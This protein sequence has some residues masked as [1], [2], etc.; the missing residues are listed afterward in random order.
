MLA[1]R[2]LTTLALAA[3]PLT[4]ACDDGLDTDDADI[5]DIK[6]SSVKNQSIGNCWVYATIGWAESLHLTQSGEELN[7]SE[8]WVSY[9]HWFEQIAGPQSGQPTIAQL[10]KGQI[11]TGGWYG[12]AAELMRKYGVISEGKFIPEEAEAARSARQSSALSAINESLKNGALKDPV[13]RR[14][15][16]LVRK[17][18]DKAWGLTATTTAMMDQ[19]FGAKVDKTLLSSSIV[20]PADSGIMN[21]KDISVG[22]KISLADAIGTPASSF[23]VLQ[24]K[25]TYAWNEV[26]Y[27]TTTK[28][29]RD[30]FK[31]MQSSMHAGMPVIMVW[32]VD[33]AGL[34]SQ[35]EFLAPPTTPG[36]QGGHMTIV[37]DYQVSNVPG[38]GTLEAGTLITD[39]KAL[40]AALADEAT[41]DFIRMKNSWGSSLA[42]PEASPD[43]RGYYDIYKA[44]IDG[45]ITKCKEANG[46][47][48]GQKS[49]GPGL[50]SLVLPPESFVTASLVKEGACTDICV[51][52]PA[53]SSSCDEC[54]DLICSE[55]AFCCAN[56]W[57]DLCVQKA[58]DICELGCGQ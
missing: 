47:K 54:T 56:A 33:F 7:L 57:D 21:P 3:L 5:T 6:N 12:V 50:T 40:T 29:R 25:G 15:R 14:D 42:P 53:R 19:T 24:R 44:Y 38:F 36:R 39:N 35:N 55:D 28:A 45:P 17:E 27:P 20:I 30:F 10:D 11:G 32:Y 34:N 23:N 49:T 43:L 13:A 2:F 51:A 58:D 46:D 18:L 26:S 22:K 4:V 9:W 16:A 37:E 48:C 41:I 8:S 52:G 1:R 31:K